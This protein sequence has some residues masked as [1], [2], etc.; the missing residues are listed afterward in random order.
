MKLKL[1]I[2][3][4]HTSNCASL[5]VVIYIYI[6]IYQESTPT[7]ENIKEA[8]YIWMVSGHERKEV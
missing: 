2:R 5:D 1:V 6:Y 7:Y 8:R 4:F 3:S